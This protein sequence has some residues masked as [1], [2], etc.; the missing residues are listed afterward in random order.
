MQNNENIYKK[1]RNGTKRLTKWHKS[2][3]INKSSRESDKGRSETKVKDSGEQ[4][5]PEE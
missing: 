1:H 2:D 3:K 4:K 5:R